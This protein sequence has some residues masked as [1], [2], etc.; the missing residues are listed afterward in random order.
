[1]SKIRTTLFTFMA[2]AMLLS[3]SSV[4]ANAQHPNPSAQ[5]VAQARSQGPC[6]DPWITIAIWDVFASTRQPAGAGRFGECDPQ[7]YNNGA[8][9]SYADLYQG[10]RT[11]FDNM[12]GNARTTLSSLPNG[13]RKIVTDAGSGFTWTQVISN[14]GATL[15][16]SDGAGVIASGGGN[17][18]G[19]A[20]T[21]GNER[22]IKLGKSVLIIRKK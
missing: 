14:D 15:I 13:Q 3:L 1:M 6:S 2:V 22:R 19:K 4:T 16:T 11:A 5:Q 9:S 21:E 10:V 8:W 18:S 17:F 20:I 7:R 12:S